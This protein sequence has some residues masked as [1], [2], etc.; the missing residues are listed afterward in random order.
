MGD[1]MVRFIGGLALGVVVGLYLGSF[2]AVA[3]RLAEIGQIL[4]FSA[5]STL[6]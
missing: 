4:S 1:N 5:L 3:Q 2:P 6:L